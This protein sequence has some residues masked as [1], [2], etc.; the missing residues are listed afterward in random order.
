MD[1]TEVGW[2]V[3]GW[4]DL[5]RWHFQEQ[6]EH[7]D[8]R[9]WDVNL[10]SH[11]LNTERTQK[12]LKYPKCH[13]FL[14]RLAHIWVILE[15]VLRHFF[16]WNYVGE[17]NRV[18]NF[19]HAKILFVFLKPISSLKCKRRKFPSQNKFKSGLRINQV[20]DCRNVCFPSFYTLSL[21]HHF[22]FLGLSSEASSFLW[23]IGKNLPQKYCELERKMGFVAIS[24]VSLTSLPDQKCFFSSNLISIQIEWRTIMPEYFRLIYLSY[25][26]VTSL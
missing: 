5:L 23:D 9:I 22:P 26:I 24:K 1:Q 7:W 25:L 11:A 18:S 3:S 8:L 20:K 14:V 16:W 21:S 15:T 6:E 12:V 2:H 19:S 13:H 17:I 10:C 4:T